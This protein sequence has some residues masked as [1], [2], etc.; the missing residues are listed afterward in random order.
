M[1]SDGDGKLA[2]GFGWLLSPSGCDAMHTAGTWELADPG[3]SPPD[4]CTP[5][6]IDVLV[7]DEVPLPIFD[8]LDGVGDGGRYHLAGFG[9]FH[10]TGYNFGG[11]YKAPDL[12]TA[13]CSGDERCI[14][15]YFTSGV[16]FDGET[17]GENWGFVIVKLTG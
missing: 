17:G 6:D 13:P 16:V 4:Q 10:I 8:D 5:G 7:G 15:G 12:Q 11:Q 1:D 3:S 2:G 9:L 14:S